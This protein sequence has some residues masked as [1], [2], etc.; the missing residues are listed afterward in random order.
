MGR[1][2]LGGDHMIEDCEKCHG[3]V[4]YKVDGEWRV[5]PACCPHDE[6]DHGICLSCE[7]DIFNDLVEQ[8][9]AAADAAQDR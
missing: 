5:C 3:E 2:Y 4:D 6:H 8:A 9:E 1:S 7:A